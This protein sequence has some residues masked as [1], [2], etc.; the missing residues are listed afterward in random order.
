MTATG[1][2]IALDPQ[3]LAAI[4]DLE[5]IA[6]VTVETGL[7]DDDFIEIT[8]G[9]QGDELVIVSVETEAIQESS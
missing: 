2:T 6:R 4:G 5:F 7:V 1:R 8:N 3:M 9:L